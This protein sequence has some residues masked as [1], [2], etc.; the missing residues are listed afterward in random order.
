MTYTFTPA[1]WIHLAAAVGALIV[2]AGIF[3]ARKGTFTHR[4]AGRGWAVLML[5]TIFSTLWIR[6]TGSYSWI[7]LLSIGTFFGLAA[8]VGFAIKGRISAH[9]KT[10]IGL[11]VGALIVAGAFTLMPQRLLGQMLWS[12]LNLI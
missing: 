9:R 12:S 11:Y 4:V 6:T 3:L 1:I 10:V 8:A 2:G 5:V 7:H